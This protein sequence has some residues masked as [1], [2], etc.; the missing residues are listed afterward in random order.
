MIKL[1]TNLK[2]IGY[3]IMMTMCIYMLIDTQR[4]DPTKYY[5]VAGILT[6]IAFLFAVYSTW[7]SSRTKLKQLGLPTVNETSSAVVFL[8]HFV[9]PFLLLLGLMFFIYINKLRLVFLPFSFTLFFL[10]FVNLRAF[11]EDKF[12]LEASTH[13]I[14]FLSI[15]F[16]AFAFVNALFN[17]ATLYDIHLLF[18]A[19]SSFIIITLLLTILFIENIDFNLKLASYICI[20]GLAITGLSVLLF[21]HYGSPIRNAF[22]VATLFYF[23]S[24]INHHKVEGTLHLGLMLEYSLIAT[25]SFVLL[26][27]I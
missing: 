15:L 18:I 9:L 4:R 3:A 25:L 17:L 23:V 19:I 1:R 8:Y 14:H 10:A 12:K 21:S 5:I 6:A 2:A 20:S 13:F 27:G 11:A 24:A 7:L 16:A 22:L 26:Y